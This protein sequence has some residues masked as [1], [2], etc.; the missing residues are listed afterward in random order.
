MANVNAEP[1]QMREMNPVVQIS[2][3]MEE[4]VARCLAKKPDQR[5]RSMDD[6]LASLRAASGVAL[7]G[8]L[9]GARSGPQRSITWSGSRPAN[10]RASWASRPPKG[11]S[12]SDPG[13]ILSP[14]AV[15]S[16]AGDAL[17]GSPSQSPAARASRAV[18]LAAA[19]GAVAVVSVLGYV[20]LRPMPSAGGMAA[21]NAATSIEPPIASAIFTATATPTLTA[22][23]NQAA[24]GEGTVVVRVET[25]PDGAS[26][27]EQGV[28]VCG[29]TPCDVAYNGREAEPN[30]EHK[31]TISRSGYRAETITVRAGDAPVSVKLTAVPNLARPVSAPPVKRDTPAVP[32]GYKTDIPY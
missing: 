4:T 2:P 21:T 8:S 11:S 15:P 16:G 7:S 10:A 3:A 25:E 29:N 1:Q 31:L 19:V 9:S 32:T 30:K 6:V 5:L 28:E 14:L 23:S 13:S 22:T 17:G 24:I 20:A 18:L 27:K 12:G 26:V